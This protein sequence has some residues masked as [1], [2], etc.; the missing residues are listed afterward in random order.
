MPIYEYKCTECEVTDTLVAATFEDVA[1]CHLC[2]GLM[3]RLDDPFNPF[4]PPI[5]APDC[6]CPWC[7]GPDP[8]PPVKSHKMCERHA[9][10][11]MEEVP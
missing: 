6:P 3:V 1:T 5:L 2:G 8:G 11:F 7:A 10:E 9:R 4:C